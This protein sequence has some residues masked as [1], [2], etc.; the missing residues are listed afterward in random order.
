M[1]TSDVLEGYF[2]LLIGMHLLFSK[3]EDAL[4]LPRASVLPWL[5]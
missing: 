2:K 5:L 4:P 3:R 1:M